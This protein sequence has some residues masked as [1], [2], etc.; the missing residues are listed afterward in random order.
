MRVYAVRYAHRDG[1]PEHFHGG[2]AHDGAFDRLHALAGEDAA[3]IVGGH[4]PLVLER[5]PAVSPDLDGLTV[6]IR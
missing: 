1:R 4:D 2:D 6:M 3:R 5:Y